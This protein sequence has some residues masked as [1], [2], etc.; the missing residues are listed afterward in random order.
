MQYSANYWALPA[1]A[2]WH[3]MADGDAEDLSSLADA[4]LADAAPCPESKGSVEESSIESDDEIN[5]VREMSDM[6]KPAQSR[7]ELEERHIEIPNQTMSEDFGPLSH[8]FGD[9][10][11]IQH[12]GI[13]LQ[14]KNIPEVFDGI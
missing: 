1:P 9:P 5:L 13:Q 3:M 11:R 6:L 7:E 2:P 10:T 12:L 4:L 14:K 8:S